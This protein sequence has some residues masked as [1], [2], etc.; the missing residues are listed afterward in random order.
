MVVVAAVIERAGKILIGQ[1]RQDDR[2]ALKFEFPGGKV[3][4]GETPRAALC[5]ELSEE[6]D[7]RAVIAEEI[8]RYTYRYPHRPLFELIFFRVREFEGE[9]QN[10]AFEKILWVDRRQLPRFDFLDGDVEFVKRLARET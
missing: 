4:H 7:I 3:E 2:H 5:R 10:R 9:P 8:T 6:L 1:R